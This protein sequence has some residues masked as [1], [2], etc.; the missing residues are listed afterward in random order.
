MKVYHFLFLLASL[1]F[2]ACD[3]DSATPGQTILKYD[4]ENATGPQLETGFHEMAVRFPAGKMAEHA[5]KKLTEVQ[6][7]VGNLPQDC[8]VKVYGQG[9]STSPGTVL[10]EK[11]VT[12][13]LA[14]GEW[15]KHPVSPVLTLTGEDLWLSIG[16]THAGEQQS[17]G[18]DSGPNKGDS[19]W[20][21]K[22][23][24]GQ[25]KTYADR[26]SESVNWNIRGV[27]EE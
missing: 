21:W 17:I 19:D 26:T 5:G 14:T 10:Y 22:S 27:V 7:F 16:F 11:D 25:W 1:F 13:A 4:N 23:G 6:F 18:C 3:D 15:N 24:D 8:K 12:N 20:L 2:A 9:T